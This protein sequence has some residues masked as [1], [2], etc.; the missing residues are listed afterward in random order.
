MLTSRFRALFEPVECRTLLSTTVLGAGGKVL[1]TLEDRVLTSDVKVIDVA[2][3]TKKTATVSSSL[4]SAVTAAAAVTSQAGF[5]I[6]VVFGTGLTAAQQAVF[7]AAAQRWQSIITADLPD[8]NGIDDVRIYA[9]GVAIDGVGKVLGQ[10]G[11]DSVRST[12]Q[13]LTGS[14]EFDSADLAN[15]LSNGS[16]TNVIVHE[17]GHVLGLG[18]NYTWSRYVSG[19]GGTN[20]IYTGPNALAEYR[21]MTGDVTAASVPLENTGGV[22]TADAHWR[23][24]TFANELMTGFINPGINPLSRLSAAAMM[25]I[26]YGGV[27]LEAADTYTLANA[28]P[29]VGT[30]SASQ[31]GRT[32]TLNLS[33]AADAN[34]A[35]SSVSFYRETN[36]IPGLQATGSVTPD[37]LVGTDATSTYA[38]SVSTTSLTIGSSYTF[39]A[40]ATDNAGAFSTSTQTIATVASPTPT[41]SADFNRDGKVDFN[42]LLILAASYGQSSGQ[43][44]STGDANGDGKV[45]F[46]DLLVLSASYSA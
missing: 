17:M 4:Q 31:S 5:Q 43:T 14:M 40:R 16:L 12:G 45:D 8:T 32:L 7:T 1:G 29:I 30:L 19:A 44:F 36:G 28:L 21:R 25:D 2:A 10:A 27:N 13:T 34:G 23:E 9:S 33:S 3:P 20:P 35:V 26:G 39:Y 11:P 6:E 24:A 18:A 46:S 41:V 15:M 42:D 38:A 37:T 22:G